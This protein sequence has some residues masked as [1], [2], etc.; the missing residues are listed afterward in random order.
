MNV[1]QSSKQ[2]PA[3]QAGVTLIELMM[4]LVIVGI[5]TSIAYPSYLEYTR[6]AKRAEAKA[7][8]SD[9]SARMERYYFDNN[10][11]TLAPVDLG[12]AAGAVNSAEDNY[13]ATLENGP[14]GAIATSYLIR[15]TPAGGHSD[16]KCEQLTLDSRGV[17]GSKTGTTDTGNAVECW[18]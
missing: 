7:L 2:A 13:T 3:R 5:L 16:P 12:F 11:Y 6:R 18:R 9:V 10:A 8:L 15:V 17:K 14:S 1:M 4:V